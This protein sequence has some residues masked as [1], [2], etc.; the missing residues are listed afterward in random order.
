MSSSSPGD[1]MANLFVRSPDAPPNAPE[2][3]TRALDRYMQEALVRARLTETPQW[4]APGELGGGVE[5]A[6]REGSRFKQETIKG[7]DML[8]SSDG[9]KRAGISR[10]AL[11]DR[12]NNN[13]ALGLSAASRNVRYPAW[14]FE[15]AV[16]EA[17]PELLGILQAYGPWERYLFFVQPEPLLGGVSPLDAI[18]AGKANDVLRIASLLA[19]E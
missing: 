14:Q 1:V 10:Q 11:D 5:Q 6:V 18:R 2:V 8:S 12:R 9:A 19:D 15:D 4:S 17:L 3:I 7:P 16:A 13:R